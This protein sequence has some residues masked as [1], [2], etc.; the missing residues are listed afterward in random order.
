MVAH[1]RSRMGDFKESIDC[2]DKLL[3]K[4]RKNAR[5]WLVRGIVFKQFEKYQEALESIDEALNL[6]PDYKD[7]LDYKD[8][9]LKLMEN[10]RK[11]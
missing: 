4:D 2:F 7:A 3:E 6:K 10:T 9:I 1:N 8:E 5:A 11:L